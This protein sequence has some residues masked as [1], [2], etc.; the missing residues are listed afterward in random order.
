M[1]L[2]RINKY[3]ADS[4]ICSRRKA[5]DLIREGRVKINGHPVSE[6][7]LKVDEDVDTV[8]LNGTPISRKKIKSMLS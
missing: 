5:E 2:T 8:T 3:L 6:L 1:K 7:S 4:G